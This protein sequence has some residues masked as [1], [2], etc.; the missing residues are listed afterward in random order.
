MTVKLSFLKYKNCNAV[1]SGGAKEAAA[2]KHWVQDANTD[3]LG[4]YLINL[5][6]I[7]AFWLSL[8]L[9]LN[10]SLRC[11]CI[12]TAFIYVFPTAAV[13]QIP[14]SYSNY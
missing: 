2:I 6:D 3:T 10:Y 11:C 9:P 12:S 7:V 1:E 13:A 14:N 8:K 5:S 4:I